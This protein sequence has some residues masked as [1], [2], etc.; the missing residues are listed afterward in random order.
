[1]A[2]V[3]AVCVVGMELTK[4]VAGPEALFWAPWDLELVRFEVVLE[5]STK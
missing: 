3:C 2:V 4:E 1:M 5:K